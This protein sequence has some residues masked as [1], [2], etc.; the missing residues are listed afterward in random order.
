MTLH[1]R[2][3]DVLRY[4]IEKRLPR[5]SLSPPA[6]PAPYIYRSLVCASNLE[7]GLV[8]LA[9]LAA[10]AKAWPKIEMCVD[11]SISADAVRRF[12]AD[13]GIHVEVWT[14]FDLMARLNA[15]AE[16]LLRRFAERYFWGRK[17]AFTFGTHEKLTILYADL[18]ILWYQD[19]WTALGLPQ[20]DS[21]LSAEDSHFSYDKE[22]IA[23]LSPEHRELLLGRPAYCAGLYA[24]PPGYRLPEVVLRYLSTKLDGTP[25]GYRYEDTCSIEQACL[26]LAT[27]LSGH[28]IPWLTLPTCPNEFPWFRRVRRDG[29]VAAHYAGPTRR[30]FW[31]DAWSLLS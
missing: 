3:A 10:C 12:Y 18:D 22:F 16:D 9:S 13:H 1:D 23:I 29:R 26:G 6:K 2:T 15:T 24:V 30:Q 4:R 14:P 28:G 21:L 7:M 19:P 27:K 8:S 17:S 11:E 5:M 20:V 31:R 25:D